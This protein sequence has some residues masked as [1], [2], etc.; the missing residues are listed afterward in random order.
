M[1]A[2]L[3]SLGG[4]G[5]YALASAWT[6]KPPQVSWT[7]AGALPASVEA[8]VGVLRQLGWPGARRSLSSA[9]AA[10]SGHR[11]A[12]GDRQGLKVIGA[13][14]RAGRGARPRPERRPCSTAPTCSPTFVCSPMGSMRPSTPRQRRT[15]ARHRAPGGS[16]RVITLADEHAGSSTFDCRPRLRI[17]LLTLSSRDGAARRRRAAPAIS[18][19]LPMSAA[20]EAHR[21]LEEGHTDAQAAPCHWRRARGA[22][23]L[24]T[25]AARPLYA[26]ISW[27]RN[28]RPTLGLLSGSRKCPCSRMCS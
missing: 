13:V 22:R 21:L 6:A 27:P 20:A 2:L 1:A 17:G 18:A 11:H 12:A 10:R 9:R 16:E 8:A 19:V 7:D 28:P 23:G 24:R 14:G 5:E 3:P 26:A 15:R 25:I 4:Y